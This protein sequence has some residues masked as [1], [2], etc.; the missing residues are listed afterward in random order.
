M[1]H[2][3]QIKY[4]FILACV[5]THCR[6]VAPQ[7]NQESIKPKEIPL[8]DQKKALQ[9]QIQTLG[10]TQKLKILLSNL[11]VT[12]REVIAL[13]KSTEDVALKARLIGT[14]FEDNEFEE[15]SNNPDFWAG[16]RFN[17]SKFTE[18][19]S[20]VKEGQATFMDIGSSN[21]EKLFGALCLGFSK[22]IGLE[23]SPES[24]KM[25]K[26]NLKNFPKEIELR[27][28]DALK[29]ET[30]FFQKADFIYMYS[31][32][33]DDAVMASLFWRIME[34]LPEDAILLEVRCVYAHELNKKTPF[35]FPT[36][37][38]WLAVKK[39]RGKYFYKNVEETFYGYEIKH[40]RN[41]TELKYR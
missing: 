26:I 30:N 37:K 31:P 2:P 16:Y 15:K 32:I 27:Q 33:K 29:V 21:G 40:G 5:L 1:I 22:A 9:E 28:G 19:V 38:S 12:D 13:C 20:L 8:S 36:L 35:V 10:N 34:N 39:M 17:L 25:S 11:N 3:K 4:V 14:V 6:Q 24:F 41:W 18:I 23:Y 7:E